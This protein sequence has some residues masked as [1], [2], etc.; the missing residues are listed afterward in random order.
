[1]KEKITKKQNRLYLKFSPGQ[2]SIEGQ[3]SLSIIWLILFNNN[4]N[5]KLEIKKIEIV[6]LIIAI[7]IM[8]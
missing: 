7:I 6:Q 3:V 1:M 8:T 4:G 2:R 5:E